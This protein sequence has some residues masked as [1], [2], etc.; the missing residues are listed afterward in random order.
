MQKAQSEAGK[1]TQQCW[2]CH[3]RRLVCDLTL[4][5]CNKCV[6]AGFECPGYDERKPL[7]WLEP[8]K[9]LAKS[10]KK[11]DARK[12]GV[13]RDGRSEVKEAAK[14]KTRKR[15]I[16]HSPFEIITWYEFVRL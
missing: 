2:G 12:K 10:R 16:V 13:F 8:G 5:N 7:Q 3:K 4:P 9:V 6:K 14:R 15:G 1:A 11:D